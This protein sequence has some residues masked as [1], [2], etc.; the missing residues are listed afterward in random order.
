MNAQTA[1]ATGVII[2]NNVEGAPFTMG[3]TN[4]KIKISSVMVGLADGAAV[5]GAAAGTLQKN[6]APPPQRDGDV[7]SDIV[8]HEYGHGLSWRMIGSMS[9]AL[10]GAIGE[11]A[12]D[13]NAFYLNGDDRIGEYSWSDSLGLRRFPY[14][15]YPYTYGDFCND[16]CEV[17]ND[18]EIYAAIQWKL[19]QLGLAAGFSND[20]L[21]TNFVQGMNFTP[22]APALENM[23]DGQ[24]QAA[25][26]DAALKCVIW[27]AF[28][29]GGVGVGAKGVLA[30]GGR[31]VTVTESFVL[32]PECP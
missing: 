13:A 4:R 2:A 32:P 29:E 19:R 10:A 15:G 3:G 21:F 5:K 11:G 31:S 28:A 1:G 20:A 24:L 6:P 16:G 8:F 23:R 25:G 18:G 9:G 14:E 7:D 30:R 26:D 22:A 17:H 12:S 27:H